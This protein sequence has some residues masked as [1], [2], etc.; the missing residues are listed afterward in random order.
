MEESVFFVE[1]LQLNRVVKPV[2]WPLPELENLFDDFAEAKVL[3]L[4]LYTE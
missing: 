2:F 4:D 1:Y 3:T